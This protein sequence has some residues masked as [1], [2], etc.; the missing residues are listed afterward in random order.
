MAFFVI[1]FKYQHLLFYKFFCCFQGDSG[2]PLLKYEPGR[3]WRQ[4][5]ITSRGDCEAQNT[6]GTSS[7]F[8]HSFVDWH[9]SIIFYIWSDLHQS[10]R[11]LWMD[12]AAD[13]QWGTMQPMNEWMDGWKK[14]E[15]NCILLLNI[16]N[17]IFL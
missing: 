10:G 11:L 13:G 5:G 12:C 15:K 14:C 9:F 6:P 16:L 17:D 7:V 3:G 8:W 2:G 1:S 4:L